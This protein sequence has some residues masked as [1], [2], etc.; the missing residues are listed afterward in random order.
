MKL[1]CGTSGHWT[2]QRVKVCQLLGIKLL[3]IMERSYL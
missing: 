2:Q 1:L 3:L